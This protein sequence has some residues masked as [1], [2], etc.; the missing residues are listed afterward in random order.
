MV[1]SEIRFLQSRESASN[2]TLNQW[3]PNSRRHPP[4]SEITTTIVHEAF[5]TL[6]K[7]WVALVKR[8]V[9]CKEGTALGCWPIPNFCLLNKSL[10]FFH[11]RQCK[12]WFVSE[13]GVIQCRFESQIYYSLFFFIFDV[14]LAIWDF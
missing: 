3:V 6:W 11:T 10:C 1:P 7:L 13:S 12:F 14:G 4:Q 9:I 8:D 2:L 5:V